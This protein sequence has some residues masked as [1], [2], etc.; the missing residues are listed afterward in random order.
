MKKACFNTVDLNLLSKNK[1]LFGQ[2]NQMRFVFEKRKL[3]KM[4][5]KLTFILLAFWITSSG[6]A[7]CSLNASFTFN[8]SSGQVSL[9]NTSTNEPTI[10]FYDWS[11]GSQISYSENPTF[12]QEPTDQVLCLAVYDST[13][14]CWDSTCVLVSGNNCSLNVSWTSTITGGNITFTNTSIGEP[15]NPNYAW[16]Y[17]GISSGMENPTFPYD[18]AVSEVCFAIDDLSGSGCEDSICGPIFADTT[19][20]ACNLAVDFTFN[21]V[22]SSVY[23]YDQSTNVQVGAYYDW[24]YGSQHSTQQNP[25][26][27]LEPGENWACLTVF[28]STWTCYDS[29]CVD[30]N[31]DSLGGCFLQ[32]SFTYTIDSGYVYFQN[33]STDM[34]ADAIFDWWYG[35]Q[36]STEENPAFPFDSMSYACLTVYDSVW[37]C[38]DSTCWLVD[39][40][41]ASIEQAEDV[42]FYV[43]PNPTVSNMTVQLGTNAATILNLVDGSGRIVKTVFTEE[44]EVQLQLNTLQTGMY[45]LII[46]D[47]DGRQLGIEKIIKQ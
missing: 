15:N 1:F 42:D 37:N 40:A 18:P 7:Q 47:P 11:Y 26:F 46:S 21:V 10:P 6:I 32:A 41:S 20:G 27:D 25:I 24:W 44:Q 33:T 28:D 30:I 12:T 13:Y 14:S 23:F 19:G 31:G 34:P 39:P 36:N 43:Y 22:G 2:P 3:N 8:I 17:N 45:Y 16:L 35:S 29:A 4:K 9:T 5:S 38:F